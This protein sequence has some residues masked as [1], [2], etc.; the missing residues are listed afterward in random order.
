MPTLSS[1]ERIRLY[2]VVL[3]PWSGAWESRALHGVSTRDTLRATVKPL[4]GPTDVC[5]QAGHRAP[6]D[7]ACRTG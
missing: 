4:E 3:A 6:L 5:H 2:A 7:Y 1:L